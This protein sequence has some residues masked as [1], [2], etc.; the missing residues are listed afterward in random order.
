MK[1]M[2]LC[3]SGH[4]DIQPAIT[5]MAT[6]VTEPI[7]GDC[8]KLGK[9]MNYLKATKDDVPCMSAND[10]GMIKWHVDATFVVHKDMKSHTGDDSWL[11][12]H[13]LDLYKTKS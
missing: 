8:K 5:L 4:Q 1:G 12:Y 2:F 3:N 13:L 9:M 6:R 10:T 7:E 11:W